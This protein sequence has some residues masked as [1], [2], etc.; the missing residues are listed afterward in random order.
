M[1][2]SSLLEVIFDI[3]LYR[4][5]LR[6]ITIIII[7]LIITEKTYLLD[8]E[9]ASSYFAFLW[10]YSRPG[11]QHHYHHCLK[12]KKK[13]I[14]TWHKDHTLRCIHLRRDDLKDRCPRSFQAQRNSSEKRE[15]K[16]TAG[17]DA[18]FIISFLDMASSCMV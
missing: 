6:L 7:A 16:A 12:K 4:F 10:C 18:T 9:P 1:Y 13:S 8:I 15:R 5:Y 3:D 2:V 14:F 17:N 11:Y